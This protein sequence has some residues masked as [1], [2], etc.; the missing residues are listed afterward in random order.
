[1]KRRKN[2][3]RSVAT[4]LAVFGAMASFAGAASAHVH[5]QTQVPGADATVASPAQVTITFDGPLEPTFSSL[6]VDNAA[7]TQVNTAKSHVDPKQPD[8]MS[9]A[10]PPL[11]AGR[12]TVHWAA[13]A[14]DGHRSHGDYPFNVK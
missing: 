11:A 3:F 14:S 2:I 5:P 4:S 6:K 8:V 1:M 7:G 10:L 13:V 12:Y 9:V